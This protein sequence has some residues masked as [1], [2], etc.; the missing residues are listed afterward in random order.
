LAKIVKPNSNS[1][2]KFLHMW[3]MQGSTWTH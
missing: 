2:T 1:C 3:R